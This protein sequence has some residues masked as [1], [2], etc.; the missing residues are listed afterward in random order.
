MEEELPRAFNPAS[1]HAPGR[2]ASRCLESARQT[3]AAS[4]HC[5]QRE[6][7]FTSGG[8]QSNN[9]AI[10]GFARAHSGRSPRVLISAI[11]HKAVSEAAGR[12]AREGADV[13]V[14]PVDETGTVRLEEL[15]KTLADGGGPTLVSIMWA[16]NEVGALQ[17]VDEICRLAHEHGALFHTDAVQAVGKVEVSLS[18]LPADLATVTAHKLGGPVGIGLL[19][20]RSGAPLE[21][22]TY[23]GSQ[24]G[25]LW[26]GTQNPL[27]AAGFAAAVQLA[28]QEQ[29]SAGE[30]WTRLRDGLAKTLAENLP[31]LRVHAEGARRLPNLLSVGIPGC[32]TGA[33]LLALDMAGISVSAGSACSSGSQTG[34]EVLAAMGKPS[35]AYATLRFSFGF[36]TEP[37]EVDH[38][39]RV[40]VDAARRQLAAAG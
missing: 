32:D 36:A 11:E 28:V 2:D 13:V 19:V 14:V 21:P 1:S 22:I 18:R 38:A 9:L 39:G 26:P 7:V 8:T 25:G 35:D 10:L 37:N 15:E 27:A 30:R 5:D 34:S 24:E 33:L 12:A 16:N 31:D 4:L 40:A 23:G 3:L 20:R 6:I 29:P 17:P